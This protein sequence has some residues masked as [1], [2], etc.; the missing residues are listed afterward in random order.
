MSGGVTT[1]LILPGS[2]SPPALQAREVDPTFDAWLQANNI[3]GQAFVIKLRA[4]PAKTPDSLVLELP[5]N[6][7]QN[8]TLE[9]PVRPRWRHI[10]MACGE[11][12]SLFK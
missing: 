2:V 3:G 12:S 4:T 9:Q 7:P 8:M 5:Y 10:K 6:I 11:V 1:S